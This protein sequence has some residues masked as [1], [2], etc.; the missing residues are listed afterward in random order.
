M[1][2]ISSYLICL[3][4]A[5][6]SE[7][8]GFGKCRARRPVAWSICITA[9]KTLGNNQRAGGELRTPAGAL[10]AYRWDT[11]YLSL[12]SQM[13]PPSRSTGIDGANGAHL[14]K[15]DSRHSIS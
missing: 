9:T 13:V 2:R 5:A 12:R 7:L 4:L 1:Q 15:R 14:L 11:E 6:Q 10:V 3:F 8:P